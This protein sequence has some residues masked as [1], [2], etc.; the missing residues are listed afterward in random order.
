MNTLPVVLATYL[1][2]G[3]ALAAHAEYLTKHLGASRKVS[4]EGK[5]ERCEWYPSSICGGVMR[6]IVALRKVSEVMD[7]GRLLAL[8]ANFVSYSIYFSSDCVVLFIQISL[9]C[10]TLATLCK[11]QNLHVC[12][13]VDLFAFIAGHMIGSINGSRTNLLVPESPSSSVT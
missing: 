13:M 8:C 5:G 3:D 1:K 6:L 10:V 11:Y 2:E 4:E 7:C 12:Q 9:E